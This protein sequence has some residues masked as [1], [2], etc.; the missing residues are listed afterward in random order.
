MTL[1]V[2]VDPAV[3]MS[4]YP[5]ERCAAEHIIIKTNTASTVTH[6]PSP[7]A[8]ETPEM[9]GGGTIFPNW[10]PV[11]AT[12]GP[13]MG[14][15]RMCSTN[16]LRGRSSSVQEVIHSSSNVTLR[17]FH[18]ST[19]V[20]DRR[21]QD[22]IPFINDPGIFEEQWLVDEL[23]QHTKNL[24][25]WHRATWRTCSRNETPHRH[26]S[27]D[28]DKDPSTRVSG[29]DFPV[30]T[31]LCSTYTADR[32]MVW[33]S[34]HVEQAA[35]QDYEAALR[36]YT[37]AISNAEQFFNHL[38]QLFIQ[39]KQTYV[40]VENHQA[41]SGAYNNKALILHNLKELR[42]TAADRGGHCRR[43]MDVV[44]FSKPE[45][46]EADWRR[47]VKTFM[48]KCTKGE[49][50]EPLE[51]A[52]STTVGNTPRPQMQG[53]IGPALR[54]AHQNGARDVRVVAPA[55]RLPNLIRGQPVI[56]DPPTNT[57]APA[58]K[59][60]EQAR[61]PM[62]KKADSMIAEAEPAPAKRH[63]ASGPEDDAVLYLPFARVRVQQAVAG[64]DKASDITTNIQELKLDAHVVPTLKRT[65]RAT[66]PLSSLA[67]SPALAVPHDWRQSM[68]GDD[69]DG[70]K[71][72]DDDEPITLS[73]PRV[74]TGVPY[75]MS[76]TGN[77]RRRETG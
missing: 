1:S 26:M 39:S 75:R 55:G 77:V 73:L 14:L 7:A 64:T 25:E 15:S 44:Q 11:A 67:K 12:K 65:K 70:G 4:V 16:G 58:R 52:P 61:V 40:P 27:E 29:G 33:Y 49:L 32:D 35:D 60:K 37:Q 42:E 51:V 71:D 45:L 50:V 59:T 41:L 20:D 10:H 13:K 31:P 36:D 9:A 76:T 62:M 68:Q 24:D 8:P 63:S 5:P 38:T 57:V 19:D 28:C 66:T 2:I 23:I 6:P 53:P 54:V 48:P 43:R 34:M 22:Q 69:G 72:S 17:I 18:S 74:A 30:K 46:L 47:L 56:R 3:L 21:T